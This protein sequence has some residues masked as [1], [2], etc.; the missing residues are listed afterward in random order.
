MIMTIRYKDG[1]WFRGDRKLYFLNETKGT[2]H[3]IVLDGSEEFKE[4]IGRKIA[5]P[6]QSPKYFILNER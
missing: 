4:L 6:V 1:S 3:F 5:V 2:H